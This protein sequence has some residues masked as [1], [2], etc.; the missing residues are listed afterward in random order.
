MKNTLEAQSSGAK[1]GLLDNIQIEEINQF[2][3]KLG[4]IKDSC[5]DIKSEIFAILSA[6]ETINIQSKSKQQKTK[7]NNKSNCKTKIPQLTQYR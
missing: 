6:I 3:F 1:I 4:E 2:A 7:E 5:V